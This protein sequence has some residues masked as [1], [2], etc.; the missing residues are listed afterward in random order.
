MPTLTIEP[1]MDFDEGIFP[2]WITALQPEY[3]WLGLNSRPKAVQLPEPDT[4]KVQ[5]LVTGLRAAGVDVR[6]K[7]MRGLV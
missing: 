1:L 5:R 7:E 4:A 6:L 2:G 3:V